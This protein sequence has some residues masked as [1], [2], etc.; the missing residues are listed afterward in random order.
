MVAIC[1]CNSI[2]Q[3][4]LIS[5]YLFFC[6]GLMECTSHLRS[7]PLLLEK[8]RNITIR[9]DC[10][11]AKNHRNLLAIKKRNHSSNYMKH[12]KIFDKIVSIN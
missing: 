6:H 7:F 1:K 8:R 4:F 12:K 11:S 9:R 5:F 3:A 2:R 10:Y